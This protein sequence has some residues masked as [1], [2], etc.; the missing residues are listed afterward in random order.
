LARDSVL[1]NLIINLED[2]DSNE[3]DEFGTEDKEEENEEVLATPL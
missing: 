1:N 3:T 2:S